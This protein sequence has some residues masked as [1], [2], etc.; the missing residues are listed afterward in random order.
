MRLAVKH[1]GILTVD[2]LIAKVLKLSEP[3]QMAKSEIRMREFLIGSWRSFSKKAISK[4]VKMAKDL[5]KPKRIAEEVDRIMNGWSEEAAPV[6]VDEME[7]I[8]RLALDAGYKKATN[9]ISESLDYN[10]PK[11]ESIKKA[12]TK[13]NIYELTPG[14]NLPDQRALEAIQSHQ[15]FWV[16][17]HYSENVSS[18]VSD[19]TRNVMLASGASPR[20]AGLLMQSSM[21]DTLSHVRVPKGFSGT[22]EQYFEALAANA[23]TTA[24]VHAQLR[25][26]MAVGVTTYRINAITDKRTCQRCSH[27]DGK[28]FSSSQG[29]GLMDEVLNAKTPEE[30]KH[31]QPWPTEKELKEISPSPGKTGK[32]DSD[33]LAAMGICLPP[34]HFKCRCTIDISA[35]STRYDQLQ[36]QTPPSPRKPPKVKIPRTPKTKWK[37]TVADKMA[38]YE[39]RL[40][41]PGV[42]SLEDQV[43]FRMKDE[44]KSIQKAVDKALALLKK[45]LGD[46]IVPPSLKYKATGK[47]IR[48]VFKKEIK[49][50]KGREYQFSKHMLTD[51]VA[52][53]E[54][55]KTYDRRSIPLSKAKTIPIHKKGMETVSDKLY[56]KVKDRMPILFET[57][58]EEG[59]VGSGGAFASRVTTLDMSATPMSNFQPYI[60]FDNMS[61]INSVNKLNEYARHEYGHVLD[62][63]GK[64][65]H[66]SVIAR[67]LSAES[68]TVLSGK[69][70]K[71]VYH[72]KCNT[73]DAYAGR[74]Y[75]PKKLAHPKINKEAIIEKG[76]GEMA[77][78]Y[79]NISEWT[80][81]AQELL[82]EKN[83]IKLFIE[84]NANPERLGFLKAYLKGA[85]VE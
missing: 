60:V 49:I 6:V 15:V 2:C 12:K 19:T 61:A 82:D 29:A 55:Q 26:F 11:T 42:V 18:T 10:V 41:P 9:Q 5:E 70:G 27:M 33:A 1:Q 37:L 65:G 24:R 76:K 3:S 8:F 30:I 39:D 38:Y 69:Y 81:T 74:L 20:E 17:E 44:L 53:G 51:L 66:A 50:T 80:S 7:I 73:V 85:F 4:A 16:G 58:I 32:D 28:E 21:R 23:A 79:T 40:A 62:N 25:S 14:F 75:A 45:E 35:E 52:D 36:P 22:D 83:D 63:I 57:A 84:W 56:E 68:G 71:G 46:K 31:I 67:N 54:A 64:N 78:G 43:K 34:F 77:G 48:N 72:I 13:P 47:A 59:S